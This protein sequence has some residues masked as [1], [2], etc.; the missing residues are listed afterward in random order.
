MRAIEQLGAGVFLMS[1]TRWPGPRQIREIDVPLGS[2]AVV[3][4]DC[5]RGIALGRDQTLL[6]PLAP[7]L[8]HF[9]EQF[10]HRARLWVRGGGEESDLHRLEAAKAQDLAS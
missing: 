6:P 3:Q 2:E 8:S 4:P 5:D 9:H 10:V 7:E 1:L